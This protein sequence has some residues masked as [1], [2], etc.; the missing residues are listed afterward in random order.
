MFIAMEHI[1]GP[2]L[3]GWLE[4]PRPWRQ[5]LEV[6]I[7]AG[8][9]LAAA[10]QVKLVH[11]DFKPGNVM[12]GDDGRV[13][14]LDF[15]LVYSV[16]ESKD[17]LTQE[18]SQ[19]GTP[20]YMAPEQIEG[21]DVDAL[22]DQFAFCT[23]AFEALYGKRPFGGGTLLARATRM[24]MGK[25]Q[26]RPT[27]TKVPRRVHD[28]VVR[29]LAANPERRW[30]NMPSLLAELEN[31]LGLDRRV[32]VRRAGLVGAVVIAVG[33]F[34]FFVLKS[35]YQG[36]LE[37]QN[38]A[39]SKAYAEVGEKNAELE[40][41]NAELRGHSE[42]QKALRVASM[43]ETPG[44][45]LAALDLA[46][47]IY[48]RYALERLQAPLEVETSIFA[49]TQGLR[50]AWEVRDQGIVDVAFDP[51]SGQVVTAGPQGIKMWSPDGRRL[52]RTIV[53]QV[54]SSI[55]AEFSSD[56]QYLLT[57]NKDGMARLWHTKSG[58]LKKDFAEFDAKVAHFAPDGNRL[59]IGS[60]DG[61]LGVWKVGVGEPI[62]KEQEI[63]V[64][65]P[66]PV[67]ALGFSLDGRRVSTADGSKGIQLWE[68]SS[69]QLLNH[70]PVN[71]SPIVVAFSADGT[72]V[73]IADEL[74][75]VQL[76]DVAD[77]S[78]VATFVGR[79]EVRDVAFSPDGSQVATVGFDSMIRLWDVHSKRL[80][81]T[82]EGQPGIHQR[83]RFSPTGDRLAVVGSEDVV[84]V[85]TLEPLTEQRRIRGRDRKDRR[86]AMSADLSRAVVVERERA[87]LWDM[88][89]DHLV[90]EIKSLGGSVDAVGFSVNSPEFVTVDGKGQGRVF[91]AEQGESVA[92]LPT[93][94]GGV[95]GVALSRRWVATGDNEGRV[96]VLNRVEDEVTCEFG[97]GGAMVTSLVLSGE[98]SQL[99]AANIDSVR[100]WDLDAC[101]VIFERPFVGSALAL[102]FSPDRKWLAV[103]GHGVEVGGDPVDVAIFPLA[104]G[105]EVKKLVGAGDSMIN[106]LAF[107]PDSK[108]IATGGD[109]R[110]R[111]WDVEL[112]RSYADFGMH[113]TELLKVGFSAD[114]QW[115]YS[116][117]VDGQVFRS[118]ATP[119]ARLQ[120][121]C[122]SRHSI[123]PAA[124]PVE[125][126]AT[127]ICERVLAR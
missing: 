24:M 12:V 74:G 62:A 110:L 50:T 102:A 26:P 69:G 90:V 33:T 16:D 87:S 46:I 73:A 34:S 118:L 70:M 93:L 106:A 91:T 18:G 17:E 65:G 4:Q 59:A 23:V 115:L 103:A 15:G 55:F 63:K 31:S 37:K 89:S 42:I 51:E 66:G 30:P 71:D 92:E 98:G 38:H 119:E 6:L 100:V 117:S 1:V 3:Q 75:V 43:A 120:L 77:G 99:A 7:Q 104:Q 49:A 53:A 25:I 19:P 20:A 94:A 116:G 61:R 111:L 28:A 86:M 41:K 64:G 36:E 85:W 57:I 105:L 35:V 2:T 127:A 126:G 88:S 47:E 22:T 113:A 5:V 56:R 96:R 68:L 121:A 45:R 95:L 8:R 72:R 112:E 13:R 9:G 79:L 109:L 14:V 101:K 67:L 97:G 44:R 40:Q 80:L 83:V 107:S 123:A 82:L 48:G 81:D 60:S 29:G 76:W 54:A 125:T 108:Q 27:K 58:E 10:H 21:R 84:R 78:L 11:R 114:G 122:E 32:L 52:P 124:T 39:L